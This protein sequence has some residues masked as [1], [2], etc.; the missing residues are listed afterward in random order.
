M[1]TLKDCA[2]TQYRDRQSSGSFNGG[3]LMLRTFQDYVGF[4]GVEIY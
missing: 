4:V 3:L 2:G 1:K